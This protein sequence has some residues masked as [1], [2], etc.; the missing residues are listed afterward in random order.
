MLIFQDY[1][2]LS[3]FTAAQHCIADLQSFSFRITTNFPVNSGNSGG[4]GLATLTPTP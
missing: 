1:H 2:P 3:H 4:R